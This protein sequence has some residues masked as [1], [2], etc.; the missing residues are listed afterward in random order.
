M[1][2][3]ENESAAFERKERKVER[4]TNLMKHS[5]GKMAK[6]GRGRS[7]G[8]MKTPKGKY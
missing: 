6:M 8:K 3:E 7:G 2:K 1:E 5:G 4:M